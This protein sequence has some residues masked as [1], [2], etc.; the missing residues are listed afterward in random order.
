MLCCPMFGSGLAPC[1]VP[2]PFHVVRPPCIVPVPLLSCVVVFVVG[3]EVWCV[4][5]V[6]PSSSVFVFVVTA[7]FV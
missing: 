2:L 5:C 1:I 7:L 6:L 3:G 4:G